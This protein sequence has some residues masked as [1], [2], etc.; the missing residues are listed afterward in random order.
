MHVPLHFRH[1]TI[2]LASL[3]LLL[4]A[5]L[6]SLATGMDGQWS[7]ARAGVIEICSAQGVKRIDSVSGKVL[8]VDKLQDAGGKQHAEGHCGFCLPHVDHDFILPAFAGNVLALELRN[9]FPALFYQSPH[10]LFIWQSAQ[11]RAPPALV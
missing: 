2:W 10:T 4:N 3:A 8:K 11:A 1:L 6:P 7:V 5:F 9:T